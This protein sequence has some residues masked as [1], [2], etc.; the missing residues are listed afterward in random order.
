MELCTFLKKMNNYTPDSKVTI[1][2]KYVFFFVEKKPL[3]FGAFSSVTRELENNGSISKSAAA[4]KATY[5]GDNVYESENRYILESK[6]YYW[7]KAF[8]QNYPKEFQVYYEDDSFICYRIVQNEYQLYNFA[9][10]YGFNE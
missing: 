2:T 10:D 1:P 3:D 7:A 9:I 6:M 5:K 4:K 8:E